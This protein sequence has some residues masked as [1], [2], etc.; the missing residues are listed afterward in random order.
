MTDSISCRRGG[1]KRKDE[2]VISRLRLGHT[3]LNSTLF[4][5]G[6]HQDGLCPDCRQPETVE[7]VL[8]TC[9]KYSR[10]RLEFISELRHVGMAEV[11]IKSILDIGSS[12]KGKFW[13]FKYLTDT[14]LIKRI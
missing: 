14:G 3:Y 6:K 11:S 13:L 9:E 2:V 10:E 8:I 12:G 4:L 1:W 5:L 7:H